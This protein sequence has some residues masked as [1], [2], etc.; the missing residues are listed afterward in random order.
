MHFQNTTFS[1]KSVDLIQL[2]VPEPAI[3][4]PWIFV[5]LFRVEIFVFVFYFFFRIWCKLLEMFVEDFYI[6]NCLP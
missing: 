1:C 4:L 3:V 5:N 6:H 2:M